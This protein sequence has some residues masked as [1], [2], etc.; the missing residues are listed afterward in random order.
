MAEKK[1]PRDETHG[2][3]DERARFCATCGK[4]LV[5][6]ETWSHGWALEPG[7]TGWALA[8]DVR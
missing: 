1:C 2:P 8:E 7:D 3:H 4:E 6:D 5:D